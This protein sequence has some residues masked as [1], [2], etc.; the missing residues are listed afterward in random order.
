VISS[1]SP[2][3]VRVVDS[4]ADCPVLPIV[5]GKGSARV[6]VWPGNGALYRTFQVF[7]LQSGDRT[8]DLSHPTDAVYYVADGTGAVANA[9][10]GES[11]PLGV[12]A[13]IHI[14]RGDSYR[15]EAGDTGMRL[16]GGPCP[17][18]EALYAAAHAANRES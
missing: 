15:F 2:R 1:E 17:A 3:T 8:V 13:M 14:D 4:A 9:V 6:V 16:I 10:S 11:W 5:H 12:G 7:E 18:D